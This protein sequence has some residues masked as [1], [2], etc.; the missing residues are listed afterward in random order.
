MART[1]ARALS[2]LLTSLM[3]ASVLTA[4]RPQF[5]GAELAA[6]EAGAHP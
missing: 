5:P 2:T 1:S 6:Q 4:L 3:F